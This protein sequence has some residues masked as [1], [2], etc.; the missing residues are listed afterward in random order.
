M[1]K[2]IC[3]KCS[4]IAETDASKC[5]N[6]GAS[7]KKGLGC[8]GWIVVSIL[9][10]MILGVFGSLMESAENESKKYTQVNTTN[11]VAVNNNAPVIM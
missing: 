5:P 7:Y 1:M 8:L 4:V 2:K 3:R 11:N 10:F 9:V 6:C